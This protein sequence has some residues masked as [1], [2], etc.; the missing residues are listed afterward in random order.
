VRN[1]IFVTLL[2]GGL[3]GVFFA[4]QYVY[5]PI[6]RF[7]LDHKMLFL[8]VPTVLVVL[9]ISVWLGF[10]RTFGF[11]PATARIWA[12][13]PKPSAPARPGSGQAHEFPG[14]GREFMPP[15]DEGSFLWMPTT[16]PHAS[17]GEVLEVL[18][19]RTWPS[20]PCRRSKA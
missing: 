3:L 1:A 14:L 18:R 13:N 11:I 9:G 8:A 20:P 4:F 7:C 10:D 19:S 16:M 2:V 15:L 12:S 17:I 6:L 5:A